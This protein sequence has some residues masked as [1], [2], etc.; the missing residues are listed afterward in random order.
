MELRVLV[1]ALL[2]GDAIRARQWVEDAARCQL[3]WSKLPSPE[4]LSPVALAVAA[5]VVEMMA[6][7]AGQPAPAWAQAAPASPTQ[8]FLVRA[9]ET[10]PRLRRLCLEEGPEPLRKRGILVPPE[11]LTWA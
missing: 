2:Q 10:M 3:S 6:S 1:E 5:G 11:F 7:R 9:A 4:N 8:G